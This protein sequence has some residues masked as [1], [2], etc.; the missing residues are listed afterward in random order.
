MI[1]DFRRA[2][3]EAI[4]A[5]T[6][7]NEVL[8]LDLDELLQ[9]SVEYDVSKVWRDPSAPGFTGGRTRATD[10]ELVRAYLVLRLTSDLSYAADGKTVEVEKVYK[11]VGRPGKGG[12]VDVLVRGTQSDRSS[13]AA[14][15]FIE[16][17]APDK[18]DADLKLIDG[19]LFRLSMLEQPRP[20]YL[21]YYT[22]EFKTGRLQERLVLIDTETFATFD[23]WDAAGQPITDAL[24]ANYGIAVKKLFG[25]VQLENDNLRPLDKEA[26]AE[27][28]NRLRNEIHDVIWGGGGTNNNE[29]F[30]LI[31]RLIL[32]K[33][34]DENSAPP[35]TAYRFQRLGDAIRPEPALELV[36]RLNLLYKEAED[37]YLSLSH[38][39]SGPAFDTSRVAADKIAY[40]VGRLEGISVTENTHRGDLLGEFF[41]QIVAADFTQTKGQF[42]TP[43]KIIRFMMELS[44]AVGLAKRTVLEKKDHLGRPRLPYVI[45]PSAG[46]GSFLIEYMRLIRAAVGDPVFAEGLP[47]RTQEYHGTWFSGTTGNAWAKEYLFGVENNYDLGLA[48][49]VNMVL[50][51]DGS[52]N[53]W[54]SSGLLPFKD[55]WIDGRHN[56]LGTTIDQASVAYD[57]PVNEQFDLIVSNPPF[58]IKISDDEKSKIAK[59]FDLMSRAQSEAIFIERW[60]QL[61]RPGGTFCCVLPEAV[62]DTSTGRNM[63][64]F[65]LKHFRVRAAV[66]LPYDAFRPFTSTK[67][68]ILLAE[69]RTDAEVTAY[70]TAETKVRAKNKSLSLDQAVAE[71]LRELGWSEDRIFMAEPKSVGYKRR[72]N[73][74]DLPTPNNLYPEDG[75]GDVDQA[76][77]A[78]SDTVLARWRA[79]DSADGDASLGFWTSL[80]SIAS[81]PGLRFD[82]KYRWLWD[83]QNGVVNGTLETSVP[84]SD[85]LE[86]VKL[87]QVDKGELSEP[88]RLIDLEMVE[89]RQAVV[90]PEVPVVD[91]I[92]STRVRFEGADLVMSKLEPYLA[93]VMLKPDAKAIGSTEWV[94][95]RILGDIPP[96]VLSYFLMQRELSDAYRRLQSGKRHARMDPEEMLELRVTLPDASQWPELLAAIASRRADIER[97]RTEIAATRLSI[98]EILKG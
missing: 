83:E 55:Y 43:V 8:A 87:P 59:A 38:P 56:V 82:P 1:S 91:T 72:K 14:F 64:A 60:F 63:R 10:E 24:P 74:P 31:T 40:V 89:S 80:A 30:V 7:Y 66:S 85:V 2:I 58:S 86:L 84:L 37:S 26:S 9:G 11:S 73:L 54:I 96:L 28:F 34:Y 95:F 53:T 50:H 52:A 69:K 93:K 19:Q 97:L 45:D 67:C 57:A 22:V 70:Q 49:K 65:I 78:G 61:L 21:V 62:A 92:G 98:D 13:S 6:G 47:R 20:R 94:G 32:A 23:S 39:S 88:T 25:F 15:L 81:R 4:R 33:I 77:V 68:F 79:G 71:T 27:Q 18:F 12:R 41:E 35:G 76:R 42:F 5:H 90:S 75:N 44:D 51:G 17:K 3:V 29:V 46:S 36:D 48:A 16:C